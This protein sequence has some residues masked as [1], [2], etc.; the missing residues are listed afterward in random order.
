MATSVTARRAAGLADRAA[1]GFVAGAAAAIGV[2]SLIFLVLRIAEVT[3]GP[4]RLTG[5]PTAGPIDAGFADATFDSVA[6][7]ID[8]SL[9][10]RLQLIGSALLSSALTLGIC[11]VVAWLC[12]RVF[13]QKPFGDAATWSI[14]V[15]ALLV[16]VSGL[17]APILEGM[18]H[19]Q[20]AMA[21]GTQEL[22]VRLAEA[23]LAP[24]G[25]S[26][27]LGV[28]A[29]VFEIGRRLQRDTEGLV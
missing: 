14:I 19:Q 1:L 7:T 2:V 25:W 27:A 23:D 6:V 26:L 10:G 20:A 28:V 4:V 29:A 3:T 16:F 15:V 9:D 22:P 17:G 21:L 5:V 11:A 13:V 8:L 24:V 18:A 12:L